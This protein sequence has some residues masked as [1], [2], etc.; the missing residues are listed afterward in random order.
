M[1]FLRE[2]IECKRRAGERKCPSSCILLSRWNILNLFSQWYFSVMLTGSFFSSFHSVRHQSVTAS[3][4]DHDY[5][6]HHHYNFFDA[7]TIPLGPLVSIFSLVSVI[8]HKDHWFR[9][10]RVQISPIYRPIENLPKR[11][12]VFH[13]SPWHSFA[14]MWRCKWISWQHLRQLKFPSYSRWGPWG[15]LGIL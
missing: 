13:L 5:Y 9:Q 1:F 7:F 6:H 4:L 10:T 12:A 15:N 8:F 14:Y 3:T 2:N 11:L